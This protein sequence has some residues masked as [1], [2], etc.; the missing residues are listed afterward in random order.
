MASSAS[1]TTVTSA[2]VATPATTKK[3]TSSTPASSTTAKTL[4]Q[5]G[6]ENQ[7]ALVALGLAILTLGIYPMMKRKHA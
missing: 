5:T 6:N 1:T 4:P 2:V 7:S 3:A